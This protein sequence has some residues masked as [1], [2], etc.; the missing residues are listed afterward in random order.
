MVIKTQSHLSIVYMRFSGCFRPCCYPLPP[1]DP[2]ICTVHSLREREPVEKQSK[3][4]D[5]SV[6]SS[7]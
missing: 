4:G 3:Q 6:T 7:D 1:M 2:V 5:G